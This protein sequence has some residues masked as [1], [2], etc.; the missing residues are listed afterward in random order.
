MRV[1]GEKMAD[2]HGTQGRQEERKLEPQ[3]QHDRTLLSRKTLEDKKLKVYLIKKCITGCSKLEQYYI[4]LFF[5]SSA[6]V[7]E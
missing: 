7:K 4:D 2:R 6:A 5:H 1:V 3:W